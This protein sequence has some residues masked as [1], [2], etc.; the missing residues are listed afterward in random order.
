MFPTEEKGLIVLV[1]DG[2]GQCQRD[3]P[4]T[5]GTL[6]HHFHGRGNEIF[7]SD[8]FIRFLDRAHR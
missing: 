7:A 8:F 2:L 6:A 1:P 4:K 5:G 3:M